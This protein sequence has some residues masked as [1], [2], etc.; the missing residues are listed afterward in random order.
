LHRL[1]LAA[2]QGEG[3]GERIPV[4]LEIYMRENLPAEIEKPDRE[5]S[6]S[7]LSK[8]YT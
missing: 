4:P 3:A 1:F 8:E 5:W 6:A 7:F 2:S